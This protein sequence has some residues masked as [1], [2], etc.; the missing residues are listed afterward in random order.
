MEINFNNI[1][2][3]YSDKLILN[4]FNCNI[5]CN[6]VNAIIGKNGCGKSTILEILD[7]LL[8]PINGYIK[9]GNCIINDEFFNN[10]RYKIGYLFQNAEEQIFNSSVY[11]EIEFGLNCFNVDSN[12]IKEKII[13]SLKLVDM[14][15][16]YLYK[17]PY[18]LS[19]GE[20]RRVAIASVLAFDPDIII[21]DE[22]TIGLDNIGKNNLI[23]LIKNL[24]N[25]LKKTIILVSHD[26][27]FLLKVTDYV[28][29]I[30]NGSVYLE[31]DKYDVLSNEEAMNSCGLIVPNIL[32]FSNRVLNK[33]NIKIGYR[34]EINDLIK[35]VY[36]YAKW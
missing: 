11:K 9:I 16:T 12:L 18:K 29:L 20:K 25:E 17:S 21:M 35:D 33:K 7:G 1:T 15:E 13:Y 30:K 2:F 32:H 14:D 4:N 24:K 10:K 28:Y 6:M 22:P 27:E 8:I 36:R 34:N 3:S 26:M 23:K 5:K 19:N 31:G